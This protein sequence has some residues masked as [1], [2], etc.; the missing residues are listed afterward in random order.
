MTCIKYYIYL[1]DK[2]I[3][4]KTLQT[5]DVAEFTCQIEKETNLFMD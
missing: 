5:F 4:G 2:I 1:K 3:V